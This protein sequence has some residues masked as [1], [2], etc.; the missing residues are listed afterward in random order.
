M[1]AMVTSTHPAALRLRRVS[2]PAGLA[3]VSHAR[4]QVRA[5]LSA[6]HVPVDPHVAALLTSE[7]VTNAVLHQADP[8]VTLAIKCFSGQLRVDVSDNSR[9][10]PA[11]AD[12]SADAES[13]RGLI[14]V[15]ALATEWGFYPT[16][17]GK[18]V[19]F[20]LAFRSGHPP[21]RR[22]RAQSR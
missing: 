8:T 17:G 7:L 15:A 21:G 1:H 18:T 3:A 4:A 14:L 11:P 20:T 2:L 9:A 19:Y 5:A 6:W 12:V 10:M 16:P 22:T 13:G